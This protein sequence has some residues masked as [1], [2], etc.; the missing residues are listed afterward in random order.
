MSKIKVNL[1]LGMEAYRGIRV[2]APLILNLG[3]RWR[4]M[5]KFMPRLLY[6]QKITLAPTE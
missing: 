5:T 6:P 1:V 2:V 3:T 4:R